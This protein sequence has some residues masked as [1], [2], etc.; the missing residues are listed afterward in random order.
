MHFIWRSLWFVSLKENPTMHTPNCLRDRYCILLDRNTGVAKSFPQRS[1]KIVSGR[2]ESNMANSL[3]RV[4]R[5]SP[6]WKEG[7]YVNP[8][9]ALPNLPMSKFRQRMVEQKEILRFASVGNFLRAK[10]N[11]IEVE[12]E[13]LDGNSY[14]PFISVHVRAQRDIPQTY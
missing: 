5:K 2:D 10:P 1:G 13:V 4:R 9:T 6:K 11:V 8:W 14:K 12:Q 7:T 3:R